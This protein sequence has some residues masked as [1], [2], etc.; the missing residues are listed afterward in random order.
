MLYVVIGLILLVVLIV[1]YGAWMRKKTYGRIDRAETRRVN[2]M[3]RPVAK[4]LAKVKQLKM[5]GD[6]E[7]KFEKWRSEWDNIVTGEFPSIEE[8]LFEAEGLTDKYRF[9]KAQDL[10]SKLQAK[11]DTMEERIDKILTELN[12][13]VESESKNRKDVTPI[14][15]SYHQIK[16]LM[17][18]K[19]SQFKEALP[20]L[21]KEVKD[22]DERYNKY[23]E[24]TE[25]GNYIEARNILLSVKADIDDVQK[26]I[27]RVP[28]LYE[29]I[30]RT[31][32]DQIR[33]LRQ[34]STEMSSQGYSLQH[35]QIDSQ[36]DEAEKQLHVIEQAVGRL[37]LDEAEEGLKGIHEQLDWLYAQLEKEVLS[38]QQL[39]EAAPKIEVRLDRVGQK[40]DALTAET[41]V[42]R[43][44]YHIDTADLQAQREI[45]KSYQ[46]LEQSF[47]EADNALKN[48]SDAFSSVLEKIKKIGTDIEEIET[49]ADS[50]DKKIKALRK[51]E[52]AARQTIQDLKHA[53]FETRQM[54][55]KSNI[56]GVPEPFVLAMDQAGEQLKNVNVKLDQKPLNMAE[57]R[58]A[59]DAAK[60]KAEEVRAQAEKLV[61]TAA[62]AEEMIRYGNR[63]RSDYP[64]IDRELQKAEKLF[65]A[66]DYQ[67]SAE[68][69]VRA[70]E[71]KEPKILK[72]FDLYQEHQA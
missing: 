23:G 70:I 65:R 50:F 33:E 8:S 71:I 26:K 7:K 67:A 27:D 14:K 1:A 10:V 5:A 39:H 32:P 63:Y 58:Q 18:T 19:R 22:I 34:G 66:Y 31:I 47:S 40:I 60:A 24:E 62:F 72:R 36:L 20:L 17:I 29:D 42:V 69:A 59:L 37:E 45:S 43:D 51:D 38:R 61:D 16:K 11:M 53:L 9:K 15:E 46:K 55:L 57:V 56:P 44:S 21:E 52:L 68:T 64:D 2:M 6:T 54:V 48:H 28:D 3:N 49:L 25:N 13:V 41:G 30:Q 35:L 12:A 4:E